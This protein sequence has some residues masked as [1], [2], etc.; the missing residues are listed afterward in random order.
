[1]RNRW[2]GLAVLAVSV[3]FSLVTYG[4][5]PE[6]VPMHWNVQGRVDGYGP[7]WQLSVLSPGLIALMWVLLLALPRID[8]LRE[9]YKRFEGTYFLVVNALIAFMGLVHVIAIGAA[10]GWP[11]SIPG[12][13][14]AATGVMFMILGNEMGRFQ[15]NWFMGI[16]TPWTLANPDVWRR[17][18]RVGGRVFVLAGLALVLSQLLLPLDVSYLVLMVIIA[19]LVIGLP[20]YSYW[21]WRRRAQAM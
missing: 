16:R 21:L 17:T 6:I 19:V 5:L 13:I 14:G 11:I 9:S 2:L 4:L 3:L 10:L 7:R 1:M 12:A 18:H 15:P 20:A 8:P